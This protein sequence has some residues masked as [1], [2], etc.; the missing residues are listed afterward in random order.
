MRPRLLALDVAGEVQAALGSDT[1]VINAAHDTILVDLPR[2]RVGLTTWQR[3]GRR[4]QREMAL[5][6]VHA[7]LQLADL[8]VQFRLMGRIVA[9]LGAKAHPGLLSW[10]LGVRPLQIINTVGHSV[11]RG[12]ATFEAI[13]G[14]G[15]MHVAR[16][17]ALGPEVVARPGDI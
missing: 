12:K 3:S 8:T 13:H 2:W 14:H 17:A 9:R 4:A 10:A 5:Q 6:R 16:A 11:E 1:V 7:M 15:A